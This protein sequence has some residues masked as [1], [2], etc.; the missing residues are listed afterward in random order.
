[1]LPDYFSAVS[2]TRAESRWIR[3]GGI[4]GILWVVLALGASALSGP[5]P[6]AD[7]RARTYQGYFIAYH[8]QLV[9]Q[10][11]MYAIGA[12]LLLMFAV[13]VRKT[14]QQSGRADYLSE[15]F[16]VGTT[17]V[18][19]VLLV[20]MAMQIAFA[21]SADRIDAEVV[22]AVG[23]HFGAVVI[24]LWGFTVGLTAFAYAYCVFARGA[25]PRWTGYLAVV[26]LVVNIAGTAGVF[27]GRG[28]F[29]MEGGFSAWAPAASTT[30][31]YLGMSIA[32]VRASAPSG[33][34]IGPGIE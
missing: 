3:L 23:V 34:G 13:A 29:S 4:A 30:L 6:E 22:Y 33:S 11:W 24:G 27:V 28:V 10:G 17:V 31:W 7:G 14:M 26:A 32:L 25:A 18:A 2:A 5:G 19:A 1:M 16:L 9:A 8:D 15:V 21:Q 12:P 20:A